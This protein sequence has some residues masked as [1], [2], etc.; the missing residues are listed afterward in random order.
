MEK[1]RRARLQTELGW[2]WYANQAD[3][4]KLIIQVKRFQNLFGN[5]GDLSENLMDD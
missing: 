2:E 3:F 1:G 4:P 5:P